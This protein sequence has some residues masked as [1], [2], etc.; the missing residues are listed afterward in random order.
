MQNKGSYCQGYV[1]GCGGAFVGAVIFF[2]FPYLIV[3]LL[4]IFFV[5][6]VFLWLFGAL[7][8]SPFA[9]SPADIAKDSSTDTSPEEKP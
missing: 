2:M 3:P 5:I 1:T 8:S 9:S 6:T 7:P 4:V